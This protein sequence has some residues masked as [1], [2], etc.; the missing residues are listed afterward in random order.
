MTSSASSSN[1]ETRDVFAGLMPTTTGTQNLPSGG[2]ARIRGAS[3]SRATGSIFLLSSLAATALNLIGSASPTEARPV[4]KNCVTS[5]LGKN[6]H[7]D[8][9][10]TSTISTSAAGAARNITPSHYLV[11]AGDTVSSIA[12]HFGISTTAV[13]SANGLEPSSLIF[14]EQTLLIPTSSVSAAEE[15]PANNLNPEH[16]SHSAYGNEDALY[17]YTI[18]VGDTISAIARDHGV[19]ETALLEVNGM[20]RSDLIFS[21]ETL[22]IPHSANTLAS[23]DESEINSV[24]DAEMLANA[25]TIVQVGRELTVPDRGIM[26]ALATAL[27]ESGLRNLSWGDQDSVGLFQQRP[28]SGWGTIAQLMTPDHAA[29]LFYGGPNNPNAGNTSGLLD[30]ADWQSLPL[31]VAAQHVQNS[32]F[33]DAY[34]QWELLATKLLVAAA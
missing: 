20:Q 21:G 29:R 4:L 26:I 11:V 23:A 10:S 2:S 7:R 25:A 27:Q 15:R 1:K 22:R 34:A 9:T 19:S 16:V 8:A 24:V 33:P 32:A 3:R 5:E 30:V 14:P 18:V 13:L 28:S 12:A 6:I 17:S 31:T